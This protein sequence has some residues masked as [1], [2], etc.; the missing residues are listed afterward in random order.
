MYPVNA[1]NVNGGMTVSQVAGLMALSIYKKNPHAKIITFD[2]AVRDY[3]SSMNPRDSIVT[4]LN[5][6]NFNGG[7]TDCA[8]AVN[9]VL[10]NDMPCDLMI[11]ISDNMAWREYQSGSRSTKQL[12]DEV[13]R[14][15]KQAKFVMLDLQHGMTSQQPQQKSVLHVGG[16]TD[17][18]FTLIYDWLNNDPNRNFVQ[19]VM[20]VL[21]PE[22][23]QV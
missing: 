7:G 16:F 6:I 4:N 20:K 1:N 3:T 11:M 23:A 5:R 17:S 14:K 21:E 18:L 10:K 2:T 22:P 9:H 8:A 15:N 19:E 13:L 12:W